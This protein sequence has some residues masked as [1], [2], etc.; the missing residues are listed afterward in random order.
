MLTEDDIE[1]GKEL[2]WGG[3]TIGDCANDAQVRGWLS[4]LE[5]LSDFTADARGGSQR[6]P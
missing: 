1:I 5:W 3:G 4:A 2:Y 6:D